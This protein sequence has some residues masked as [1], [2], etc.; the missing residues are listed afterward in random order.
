MLLVIKNTFENKNRIT[1]K[2]REKNTTFSFIILTIVC[3]I[4]YKI[5]DVY[6]IA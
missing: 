4:I 6:T 2:I 5:L 3:F 1:D